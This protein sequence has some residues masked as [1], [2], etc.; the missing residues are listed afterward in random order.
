VM[1][2]AARAGL[3]VVIEGEGDGGVD[4]GAALGFEHDVGENRLV[5]A[6]VEK[7]PLS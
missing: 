4:V 1:F 7:K 5:E 6:P 3:D 2:V